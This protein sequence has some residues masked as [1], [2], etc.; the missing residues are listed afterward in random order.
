MSANATVVDSVFDSC[1]ALLY[2]AFTYIRA[3]V[4]LR[5]TTFRNNRATKGVG[6]AGG[7]QGYLTSQFVC[8]FNST[9]CDRSLLDIRGCRFENNSSPL[10]GGGA[11]ATGDHSLV[12]CQRW[13]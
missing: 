9:G 3:Q 4:Y 5:N 1:S 13:R 8:A 2:G 12:R 10:G 11:V 7:G 6:G